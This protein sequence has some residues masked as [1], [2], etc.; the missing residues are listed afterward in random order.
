MSVS[1][2]AEIALRCS[3]YSLLMYYSVARAVQA[4]CCCVQACS[5]FTVVELQF[6]SFAAAAAMSIFR[7]Y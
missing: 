3:K 4:Y 1:C 6:K 7:C 5:C 2:F